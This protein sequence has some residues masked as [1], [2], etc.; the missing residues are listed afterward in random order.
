VGTGVF[1][2]VAVG[3]GVKV[4]VGVGSGVLVAVAAGVNV[5]VAVGVGI[6]VFVAVAVGV[7]VAVA[8]LVAVSVG[9]RVSV[10][11]GVFV[12]VA[13]GT[14]VS[15]GS[16]VFDA[17]AVGT[18]VSVGEGVEV[19]VAVAVGVGVAGGVQPLPTLRSRSW[20]PL[21]SPGMVTE[22]V[23]AYTPARTAAG[24]TAPLFATYKAAAPATCGLAMLVPLL[25]AVPPPRPRERIDVPGAITVTFAPKLLYLAQQSSQPQSVVGPNPPGFPSLS[26]IDPT[27][28]TSGNAAGTVLL[29]STPAFPA[30]T[31]YVTPALTELQIAWRSALDA[32]EVPAEP[33]PLRLMLTT[34]IPLA[35]AFAVTQSIPQM[36]QPQDPLAP[37]PRTFTDQI[38]APGATPTTPS[39]LSI[40]PMVPAT[41]VPWPLLS[42]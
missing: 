19:E 11:T 38:R 13:V 39:P 5:F 22:L 8:V 34:V 37:A 4:A 15:V 24:P 33:P 35:A 16:G 41:C 28:M 21:G 3:T 27:A 12:E 23:C 30:E 1:V 10:G 36:I 14:G 20:R 40:A 9:T 18:G 42:L 31:T 25:I 29:T 17:V 7:S 32:H 2:G 6:A 26:F